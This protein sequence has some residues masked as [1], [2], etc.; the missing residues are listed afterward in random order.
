MRNVLKFLLI[1][2]QL[3]QFIIGFILS[4]FVKEKKEIRNGRKI[5]VTLCTSPFQA[6]FSLGPYVF[7]HASTHNEIIK[8]ECGHSVQSLYLGPLYLIVIGI[9]SALLYWY[10]RITKKNELWYHHHF[11]ENWANK[12]GDVD[13]SFFIGK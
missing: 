3:P 1:F 8:H 10:K 12:L 13:T 6:C 9:P 11:P 5:R 4:R 7:C 2:W